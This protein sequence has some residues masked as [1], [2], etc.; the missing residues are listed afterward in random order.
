MP[1]YVPI[2]KRFWSKVTVGE[3][4]ECW[5]WTAALNNMGYGVIGTGR[6]VEGTRGISYAHRLAWEFT[7]G[8]IQDGLLV[9]HR[10][11]NSKCCNPSH[12]YL[13][14]Y[15]DRAHH[16]GSYVP[17][18]YNMARA[19]ERFWNNVAVGRR[20]DCWTWLG[21]RNRKGYGMC[22]IKSKMRSS[23]RVAY[24]FAVGPIPNDL[25]VC[26][27]C[28]NPACVNPSHLWLGTQADNAADMKA[29]GRAARGERNSRFR[30]TVELADE[31]RN[32]YTGKWGE[33]R[34]LSREYGISNSHISSI[35]NN[36]A[37]LPIE[38]ATQ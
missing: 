3:P 17:R 35:L 12:L 14:T 27:S 9:L 10:C 21:N 31:I 33:Q 22:S 4:D 34:A 29:K 24:E 28:D 19:R 32:R 30:I 23:H 1:A 5:N 20:D 18:V 26:H 11:D 25:C 38:G 37:C 2:E 13:G 7:H 6:R 15:T 36:K 8:T 16:A